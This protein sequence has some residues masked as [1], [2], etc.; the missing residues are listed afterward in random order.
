MYKC[1]LIEIQKVANYN[2]QGRFGKHYFMVHVKKQKPINW[3]Y[4]F[5]F[6]MDKLAD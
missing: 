6:Y 1:K 3:I 4:R 2:I 5:W